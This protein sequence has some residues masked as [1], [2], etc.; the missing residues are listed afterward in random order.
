M[1]HIHNITCSLP[2]CRVDIHVIYTTLLK[3]K[4]NARAWPGVCG[5]SLGERIA[6]VRK[7]EKRWIA[8]LVHSDWSVAKSGCRG[9]WRDTE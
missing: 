3:V 9:N 7:I 4:H 2:C 1:R 8:E 6:G 5:N